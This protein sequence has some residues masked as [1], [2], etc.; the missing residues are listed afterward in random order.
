MPI[1]S[2]LYG[3]LLY[4]KKK[5]CHLTSMEGKEEGCPLAHAVRYGDQKHMGATNLELP[6]VRE[7]EQRVWTPL[8]IS[9]DESFLAHNAATRRWP[10]FPN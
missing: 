6:S 2:F 7:E 9:K 4:S 3:S 1:A 8:E 10:K 5:K